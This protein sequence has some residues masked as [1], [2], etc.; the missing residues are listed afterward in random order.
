MDTTP[1]T[2]E[3][4][5]GLRSQQAQIRPCCKEDNVVDYAVW[6]NNKLEFT[7]TKKKGSENGWVIAMKNA[8]DHVDD[9]VVQNIGR[10]IDKRHN[11]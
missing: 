6:I 3:Y 9:K 1:F 4:S 8:D 2:V 11:Y 10:E 7:I 5:T